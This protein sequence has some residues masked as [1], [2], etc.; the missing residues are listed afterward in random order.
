MASIYYCKGLLYTS[1]ASFPIAT[2]SEF[3]SA[4][5]HPYTQILS[6]CPSAAC[7]AL[8][9]GEVANLL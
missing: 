6:H 7:I 2:S 5:Y 3:R 8:V 4:T 1:Y 9:T